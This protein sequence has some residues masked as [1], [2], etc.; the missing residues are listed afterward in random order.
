[1]PDPSTYRTASEWADARRWHLV[2][3]AFPG[4]WR[5]DRAEYQRGIMDAAAPEAGHRRVV[6][7][8]A[9]MM[10]K[11]SVLEN[12]AGHL[13]EAEPYHVAALQPNGLMA[14]S[15]E[16]DRLVPVLR[17]SVG[18]A[19]RGTVAVYAATKLDD[20]VARPSR[21]VL[22]D[23]IDRFPGGRYRS[24]LAAAEKRTLTFPAPLTIVAGA[25]C[26]VGFSAIWDEFFGS[27]QRSYAVP[28]PNCGHRQVLQWNRVR[29]DDDGKAAF[30][31]DGIGCGALWTDAS[32]RAAISG[33]AWIVTAP[34]KTESAAGFHV[35][36]LC[37]TMISLDHVVAAY[38][39][40]VHDPEALA[41]W[42]ARY[43]GVQIDTEA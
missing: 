27:D 24:A 2:D 14:K 26:A 15:W 28:C 18:P 33:G 36:S 25:P 31:C 16:Q 35:S 7:M 9:A 6:I 20:L 12:I 40:V 21:V 32:R 13:I 43:L 38:R 29:W 42:Y 3:D 1:M 34:D 41:A 30:A 17:R 37:S 8:T 22:A 4:P 23:E 11:T 19:A 10:G 5:T 39:D